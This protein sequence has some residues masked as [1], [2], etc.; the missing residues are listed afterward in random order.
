MKIK[1]SVLKQFINEE[2]SRFTKPLKEGSVIDRTML[3]RMIR[4]AFDYAQHDQIVAKIKAARGN[5]LDSG[6]YDW[7]AAGNDPKT[8]EPPNVSRAKADS[9]TKMLLKRLDGAPDG[10]G[11]QLKYYDAYTYEDPNNSYD[12]SEYSYTAPCVLMDDYSSPSG[13]VAIVF[14]D[15]D[16]NNRILLQT[17]WNGAVELDTIAL[18]GFV[19]A[20]LSDPEY[21]SNELLD[22]HVGI[23]FLQAKFGG[24]VRDAY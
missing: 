6:L 4:E 23:D 18:R 5:P 13:K 8:Y 11:G 24:A 19:D 16:D 1:L 2:Y 9:R 3:R 22:G 14:L 12:D 15:A 20:M 10:N 17:S 7:V 21:V